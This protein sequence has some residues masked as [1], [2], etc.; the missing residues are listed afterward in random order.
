MQLSGLIF[1]QIWIFFWLDNSFELLWNISDIS[2]HFQHFKQEP[3]NKENNIFL[4][5][6]FLGILIISQGIDTN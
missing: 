2:N 1:A 5:L 4:L 3:N 6:L